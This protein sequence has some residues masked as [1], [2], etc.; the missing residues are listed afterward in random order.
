[1]RL[2]AREKIKKDYSQS[3]LFFLRRK[4]LAVFKQKE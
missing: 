2:F 3:E 4:A 1:V